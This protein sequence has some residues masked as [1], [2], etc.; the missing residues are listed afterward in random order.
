MC[1]VN[2]GPSDDAFVWFT[3]QPAST[4][5]LKRE[6]AAKRPDLRFAFSRPGL[7]TFKVTRARA[8]DPVA[9]SFARAH[10]RSLGR[11]TS[12]EEVLALAASP[13]LPQTSS[14]TYA[15]LHVFERDPDRPAD[16][17]A[18][19]VAGTRAVALD[20]E[21]RAAA[22]GRFFDAIEAQAGDIVLDVVVAAAEEPEDGIFVGWHRHDASRGPFPGGVPHVA[23]P[24][25]APSRAWAKIEEAIRWSG[26][27]PRAGE[28]AVELG[29]APG[30]A[31]LALLE[32]GLYVHGVDPGVMDP[33]VLMYTGASGNRFTHH[34]LPAAEVASK[35]L[36]R[37]YAWLACDVNLA[38]MIALK[39]VERFVAL[40]HGGLRGA[41]ITLKL[42]D[43]GVFEALPRLGV[44][45]AKLG[46]ARIRYTQLPSH[47]R[48]IVAILEW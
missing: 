28:H 1:A 18:V 4:G 9:C 35:D 41:F 10:G 24:A 25:A 29:S 8:D 37:S 31:S 16:E 47:R 15:R 39:Y 7:T 40:A 44:R 14:F 11:A 17:R 21:L 5:W 43:D 48:E 46:A 2:A 45:I 34:A 33:R 13:S 19:A 23:I 27:I 36:P 6:L 12:V 22:P 38:P 42:N 30:G 3:H 20:V 26:L 32:R